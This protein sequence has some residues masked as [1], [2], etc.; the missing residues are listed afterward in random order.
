M[1]DP[2]EHAPISARHNQPASPASPAPRRLDRT[3]DRV[4]I[5]SQAIAFVGAAALILKWV[6][7]G[8]NPLGDLFPIL[9]VMLICLVGV[10][11][12]AFGLVT[13]KRGERLWP[14]LAG[15]V[16]FVAVVWLAVN[17][18]LPMLSNPCDF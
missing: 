12:G 3:V 15:L 6:L 8:F 9:L 4:A 10:I 7:S 1:A 14:L 16:P 17:L 5:W 13:R 2:A 11:A 18:I